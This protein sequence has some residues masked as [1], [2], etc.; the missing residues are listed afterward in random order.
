MID[1]GK[2]IICRYEG[3]EVTGRIDDYLSAGNYRV[4]LY[5]AQIKVEIN[6]IDILKIERS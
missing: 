1:N 3:I 2:D 5:Q 4:Y 6:C